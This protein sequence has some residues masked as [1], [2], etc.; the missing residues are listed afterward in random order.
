M[1]K[2]SMETKTQIREAVRHPVVWWKGA[3]LPEEKIRPW[4]GGIQFFA[5]ALKGFMKGY[6]NSRNLIYIGM[7][8][9]KIR[10]NWESVY[11]VII[12][13]WDAINN[14]IVGS[15]M[16][17]KRYV[18]AAH[19]WIMRFNATL[20]PLLI[21]LQCFDFGLTPLQRISLW[22]GLSLF[23]NLMSTTNLVSETK[24]WAGITPHNEQRSVI[25]LCKTVGNQLSDVFNA[26]PMALWSMTSLIG[27]S[28]YQIMAY[29]ALIFAPFTIFS[30]WLPSF[31]K[32]RVD[33]TVQVK[34]EETASIDASKKELAERPPTLR[35]LF[36]VLKHN[37]W[38]M[39]TTAANMIRMFFP[40]T[41]YY[42]QFK[43]LFPKVKVGNNL[44]DGMFIWT[45]K[46]FTFGLPCLL[47]Q[48]FANKVV[49]R[50]SSKVQFLRFQ[51]LF[52]A[53]AHIGMYLVGY[54]SWP[55]L[56]ILFTIEMFRGIIDNW[57]PVPRELI[58]YEMLDYMEWKT[59]QRSEGVTM[60]L[61]RMLN[62][63]QINSNMIQTSVKD[64]VNEIINN[65][66]KEWSGFLSFVD[67][68]EDQPQRF[69]D[70]IWPLTH[71]GKIAGGLVG[72]V[73]LLFFRYPHDPKEVEADLV[74][75]RALAQR[76]QEEAKV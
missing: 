44:F 42:N 50:F 38:L 76:M 40:A 45:I 16:D 61:D 41:G 22:T 65:A 32:Q 27:L 10:P 36:S 53:L 73:A 60:S 62:G 33:F 5:E 71:W 18:E 63:A 23:S 21:L 24:I 48:P 72:F 31:A 68:A 69:L 58:K 75:R 57:A 19:R 15:F 11:R 20:S 43:F 28:E 7:G 55:R 64:N 17:R 12:V 67:K 47:L 39:V 25:Q 4:E 34:G 9:G 2:M 46:N 29:G 30:R 37:R 70:S 35:E 26:I 49:G 1:V 54:K 6:V 59:G 3:D 8:E 56:F 51:E 13:A 52:T 66:V 74:E 14:P